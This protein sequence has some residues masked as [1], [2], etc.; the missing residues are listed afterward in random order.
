LS[1]L[2]FSEARADGA[3]WGR[4]VENAVGAHLLNSL[5]EPT[6]TV[7]YWRDGA[8]EVDYVVTQGREVWA[9]EVKSGRP[10]RLSG[11]AAF[12]ARYP[13]AHALV[14]GSEGIPLRDFFARHPSDFFTARDV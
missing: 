5:P 1:R 4:V 9:V 11:L 6:S 7:T 14:V 10:A 12:R 8:K 13:D 2:S 3:W